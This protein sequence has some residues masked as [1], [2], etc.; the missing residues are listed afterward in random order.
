MSCHELMCS[1]VAYMLVHGCILF[2]FFFL[3]LWNRR[4]LSRF[5]NGGA[6]HCICYCLC[7]RVQRI[8]A[9]VHK[10]KKCKQVLCFVDISQFIQLDI[11]FQVTKHKQFQMKLMQL[12][13][14]HIFLFSICMLCW[15]IL[16][17]LLWILC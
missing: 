3:L 6:L 9:I 7:T 11:F 15:T 5:N 4:E 10:I 14:L 17:F 13:Y 2:F 16:L 1:C 8:G 12:G